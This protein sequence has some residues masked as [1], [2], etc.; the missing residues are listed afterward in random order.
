MEQDEIIRNV[1][2]IFQETFPELKEQTLN[3]EK[4]QN[5]FEN[6]D[7]FSHLELVEKVERQFAFKFDY[8]EIVELNSPQKCIDLILKK[9][10]GGQDGIQ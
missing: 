4:T 5:E 3:L 6:W 10:G 1:T 8:D 9:I 2:T 7:S